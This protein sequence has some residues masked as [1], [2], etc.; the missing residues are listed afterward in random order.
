M[1][2]SSPFTIT[3]FL[4]RVLIVVLL[5]LCK[6]STSPPLRRK[7]AVRLARVLLVTID[8]LKMPPSKAKVFCLHLATGQPPRWLI[9]QEFYLAASSWFTEAHHHIDLWLINYCHFHYA[10]EGIRFDTNPWPQGD[11]F[12]FALPP[13]LQ[14]YSHKP[15]WR[16]FNNARQVVLRLICLSHFLLV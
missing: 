7:L 5:L 4:S 8:M 3:K 12:F 1:L 10:A 13:L 9:K 16:G 11:F 14:C 15:N 2:L 6:S